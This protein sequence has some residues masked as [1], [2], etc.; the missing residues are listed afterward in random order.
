[1]QKMKTRFLEYFSL[2]FLIHQG[3]IFVLGL[4]IS[5]FRNL[6]HIPNSIPNEIFHL[7][8]ACLSIPIVF[9]IYLFEKSRKVKIINK[10]AFVLFLIFLGLCVF[11]VKFHNLIYEFWN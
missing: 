8:I 10:A 4:Y 6:D 3:A 7:K 9:G 11:V 1:M 2:L 5:L